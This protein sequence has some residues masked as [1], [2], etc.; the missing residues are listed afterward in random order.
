MISIPSFITVRTTS[1]RLPKK[2]LLPFGDCNVLEHIIRRSKFY[3]L[4]PI[5]CTTFEPSDDIIETIAKKE[6]VKCFR[7]SP[8]NKLKRW[9]DCCDHFQIKRFHTVDADDPFFDGELMKDS[10]R[11]LAEGFDVVSPT[12]S[13]SAGSASVGYSLSSDIVRKAVKLTEENTDTE[14]M[15]FYLDKIPGIKKTTLPESKNNSF[16]VRLTLDYEEDYWLLRSVQR[17]VGHLARR[18]EVNALFKRNPELYQINWF[19]NEEW[20]QG[21]LAKKI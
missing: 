8:V 14:M 6:N 9:L 16:K 13:S 11:L 17:I 10:M 3:G 18:E 15:W 7:G 1:K 2:C 20:E 19:R 21:Q 4:L 5:I 12:V